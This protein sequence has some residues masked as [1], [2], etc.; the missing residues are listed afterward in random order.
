MPQEPNIR[1]MARYRVTDTNCGP[2]KT[3]RTKAEARQAAE[4][5]HKDKNCPQIRVTDT[6]ARHGSAQEW[7]HE[8]NVT[9]VKPTRQESFGA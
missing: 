1:T 8:G 6:M 7:D 2:F 3:A 5:H 9:S 4:E